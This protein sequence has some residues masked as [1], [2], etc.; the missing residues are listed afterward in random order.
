MDRTAGI[1]WLV[2]VGCA[3]PAGDAELAE[4]SQLL[5]LDYPP[6]KK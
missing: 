5:A 4:G 2:P 3:Y 1:L 6:G